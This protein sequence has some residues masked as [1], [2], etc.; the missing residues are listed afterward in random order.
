M[1]CPL[2]WPISTYQCRPKDKIV[3]YPIIKAVTSSHVP[4]VAF[5]WS[6]DHCRD[7]PMGSHLWL[8]HQHWKLSVNQMVQCLNDSQITNHKCHIHHCF[9]RSSSC[10]YWWYS[11]THLWFLAIHKINHMKPWGWSWA[12]IQALIPQKR[13]WISLLSPNQNCQWNFSY[14]AGLRD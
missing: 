7:K 6:P 12:S 11:Q 10:R 8:D 13:I 9:H 1:W 4:A 2:N 3:C 5:K 14:E